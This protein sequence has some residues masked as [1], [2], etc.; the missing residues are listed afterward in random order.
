MISFQP[1]FGYFSE[2][3][4]TKPSRYKLVS[5]IKTAS[6]QSSTKDYNTSWEWQ[7]QL[8]GQP[9]SAESA[10]RP[11]GLVP[12]RPLAGFRGRLKVTGRQD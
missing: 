6:H 9:R 3:N 10:C 4:L 2:V 5:S 1:N 8:S 12:L 11:D 7:G